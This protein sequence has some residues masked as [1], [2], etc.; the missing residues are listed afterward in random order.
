[1]SWSDIPGRFAYGWIWDEFLKTAPPGAAVVEVGVG[2]GK[3]I[4]YLMARLIASGRTD[5]A[6][7]G[8]DQWSGQA[9]CG[10]QTEANHPLGDYQLFLDT[11]A[12][13]APRELER[14]GVV[15][16]SSL[17]AA[18]LFGDGTLD[19]VVIDAAHDY[20]SVKADIAAWTPKL[21]PG[22]RIGGDDF[23]AEYP[24]VER[25]AREAFGDYVETRS[26]GGW[27]TWCV[28]VE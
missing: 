3:S 11:M 14:I 25:A 7:F 9:R 21:I 4:A 8:V 13:H 16:K 19:L 20:E 26:V 2:L 24:G 17:E 10:E 18:A 22:G 6:V 12:K 5:I 23:V 27:G 28:R 15:R 1:M